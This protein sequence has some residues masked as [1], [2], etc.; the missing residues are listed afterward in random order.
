M[1][2]QQSKICSDEFKYPKI[3]CRGKHS[4]EKGRNLESSETP[5]KMQISTLWLTLLRR[6]Q[7]KSEWNI[8]DFLAPLHF[9]ELFNGK[10]E[11]F[12]IQL[13]LS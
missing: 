8:P 6:V 3:S 1:Q 13:W 4:E 10:F 11:F 2:M 7:K 12:N 9:H 5:I